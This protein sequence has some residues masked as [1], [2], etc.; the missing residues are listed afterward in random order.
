M[1]LER[2]AKVAES[3]LYSVL[4]RLEDRGLVDGEK[5]AGDRGQSRTV[6]RLT[7]EGRARLQELVAEGLESP[8]PL[9]SDRL[10]S[11]VF[12]AAA[13]MEKGLEPAIDRVRDGRNDLRA[14]RQREDLSPTGRVIVD[15]YLQVVTAQLD[16]LESLREQG[17]V[18]DRGMLPDLSRRD[19]AG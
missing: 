7:D 13:G 2:W 19:R 10:V 14:A 15:F 1:E 16:A 8:D 6:H 5:V 17:L 3:T 9:Y 12:A 4:R 11:A 18:K